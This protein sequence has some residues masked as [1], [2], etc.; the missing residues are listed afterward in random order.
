MHRHFLFTW[1]VILA[2]LSSLQFS[3]AQRVPFT[4]PGDDATETAVDFSSLLHVPAGSRGFVTVRDGKFFA[5]EERIRF[6]GMNLCFGANFPTH[7]EA[8]RVA[9]HLAKL[10]INSM[11]FHHMDM[12][13]LLYTSPSP[14]DQRGSRMPSSA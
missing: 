7:E 13:C 8:D 4:I 12:H 3:V 6:W 11:R 9:P 5:G 1:I 14:R 10:G 2:S